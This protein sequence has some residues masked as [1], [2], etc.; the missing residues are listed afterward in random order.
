MSKACAILPCNGL[1]KCT[2]GISR[3][4]ALL[5]SEQA[6][7]KILCP[8]FYRV[9][10]ARYNKIADEMPLIVVDGCATRCA[11]KLAAEKNLKVA[12]KVNITEEAKTR[13]IVLGD[14]LRLGEAECRL[15][16]IIADE[17]RQALSMEDTEVGIVSSFPFPETIE[18]EA[19]KKDKFVFKLP[20]EG[21]QF[22]ENDCWVYVSGNM[23]RVGVTDYVQQSLSDVLFFTPPPIG[24][25][26]E[27][28][29]ELGTIESGKAVFEVISPVSGKVVAVNQSLVTSPELVNQNSYE[30]GWIADLEL[31]DYEGDQELLLSFDGYFPILKRKVD[32]FHVR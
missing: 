18:Y 28:F 19:Y 2:G 1:D 32:A 25:D 12:N 10:D 4:I 16:Q 29:G 9:A 13:G 5:L 31:S 6:D 30:E 27:Q 11:S 21:F 17:L 22:N 23:A 15:A 20:K 14:S 8:V 24:M 3:E 7:G 26:V